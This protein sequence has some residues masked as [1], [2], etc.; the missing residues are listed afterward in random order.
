M[1]RENKMG[2][3]PVPKLVVNMSQPIMFSMLVQSMYNIVD[4][5]FVARISEDAL[6]AASIAYSAQML[7][8]A[9]AVGT[10]VG[11]NALVSRRLGAK[12]FREANE[13][14]TTGLVLSILSSLLFVLWGVFGTKAFIRQFSQ[15]EAIVAYGTTYLKICQIFAAGIFLGTFT[16]RLLQSP[17]AGPSP[18]CWRRW[19]ALWPSL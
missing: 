19:R 16:Q 13:A 1:E 3:M 8:I 14:A 11:M 9:V 6:T 10:G 5:V 4:S 2:T 12:Q 15:D 7:Q 17:P 18:V